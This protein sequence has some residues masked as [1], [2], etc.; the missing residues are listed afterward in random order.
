LSFLPSLTLVTDRNVGLLAIQA[1][2]KEDKSANN[3]V[4]FDLRIV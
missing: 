1:R 2:K 4:G 3:G